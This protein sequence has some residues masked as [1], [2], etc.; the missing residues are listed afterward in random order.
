M[1]ESSFVHLTD[2][3]SQ[4]T[5]VEKYRYSTQDPI[6]SGSFS[7]VFVAI[8]DEIDVDKKS[9]TIE[10]RAY[11][12]KRINRIA[13][14]RKEKE[15]IREIRTLLSISGECENIIKFCELI[16]DDNFLYLF[17]DL[18]DGDLREFVENDG[19]NSCLVEDQVQSVQVIK[20]IVNGLAFLHENN[21]IHGDLKPSNILYSANP[22]HFKIADIGLAKNISPLSTL[23]STRR[24][25]AAM[26]PSTRCWMT[27]ELINMKS[28]EHTEDSDIFS[29]GLI[30]HYLLTLGEHPF[31][32]RRKEPPGVIERRIQE[33]QIQINKN[34]HYEA[35]RFLKV[36]LREDPS[37]RPLVAQ[38]LQHPFLWSENKK[39]E[40][41]KA[42]GD[43]PEASK[44]A[45]SSNSSLEETLQ[46]TKT[47]KML[48]ALSWDVPIHSLYK[49]MIVSWTKNYR[50]D[51][52]IDLIR[53]I[54]N[55]HAHKQEKSSR[56]QR[57]VD[58][59]IFLREYPSLV[60][61]AFNAVKKLGLDE[62]RSNIF[63]ALCL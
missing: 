26:V 44:P 56:F 25:A 38:L 52:V 10:C 55:A 2:P 14:K 62:E 5:V 36:I 54:R 4:V 57:I 40:F 30:L 59:N 45:A 24:S 3:N 21:L 63:Q 43:Q 33:M 22:L 61:D 35:A 13:I 15:V 32:K 12:L 50:T 31:S 46:K 34:L 48:N 11:A 8:K 27:P 58:K 23:T 41:L 6:G 42:V 47:G 29:L 9:G 18:M 20:E 16:S 51:K 28:M 1:P 39:I 7:E 19:V 37:K 49:E 17:L 60:L 53:F